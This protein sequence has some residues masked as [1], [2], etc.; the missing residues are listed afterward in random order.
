[1]PIDEVMPN[2][3][4]LLANAAEGREPGLA[5]FYERYAERV[6]RYALMMSGSVTVAQDVT[7]ELFVHVL[8]NARGYD[9]GR[10]PNSMAWLYGIARNKLRQALRRR[11]ELTGTD[12]DGSP[13][14]DSPERAYRWSALIADTAKAVRLLPVEQREVLIL[15]GLQEVDYA[16]AAHV[17]DVPVGTVRSRLSRA[18]SRLRRVL[19]QNDTSL[20]EFSYE[21][22]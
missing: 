20:E 5:V 18:R 3:E 12:T 11:L 16:T 14:S 19:E 8:E 22:R 7:Q 10:S 4:I 9:R 13:S 1:M 15:C 6:Y 17:L 21:A 2:D